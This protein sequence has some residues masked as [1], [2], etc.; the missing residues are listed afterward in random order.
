MPEPVGELPPRGL[1]RDLAFVIL[2]AFLTYLAQPA[3]ERV[4]EVLYSTP[5]RFTLPLNAKYDTL[6]QLGEFKYIFVRYGTDEFL[7]RPSISDKLK[8][9]GDIQNRRC[10]VELLKSATDESSVLA[11]KLPIHHVMGT[12]FKLYAIPRGNDGAAKMAE[13]LKDD[14]SVTWAGPETWFLVNQ[15]KDGR[16]RIVPT[17]GGKIENNHIASL[18]APTEWWTRILDTFS[19]WYQCTN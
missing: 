14:V 5:E 19:I 10:P 12:Q 13:A 8:R 17:E 16:F 18:T 7:A 6:R 4:G 2:G 11:F 1:L 15:T 3:F 9:E